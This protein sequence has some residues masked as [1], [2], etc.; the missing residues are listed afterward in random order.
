VHLATAA[1]FLAGTGTTHLGMPAR[2]AV[3]RRLARG[4]AP[5]VPQMLLTDVPMMA[6]EGFCAAVLLVMAAGSLP[7]MPWWALPAILCIAGAGLVG[8]RL[9]HERLPEQPLVAGLAILGAPGLRERLAGLTVTTVALTLARVGVVLA[10]CGLPSDPAH[11][12]LVYL[13]VSVLGLLPIG[14]ASNAA[15]TL[16]TAGAPSVGAGA[17]AGIALAAT[18]IAAAVVYA[19]IACAVAAT[20]PLAPARAREG[21]VREAAAAQR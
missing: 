18:S 15:A 13:A 6:L 14:A 20:R 1:G 8:I 9:V 12:V 16:A 17:A 5:R 19:A 21:R 4:S 2:L 3:L 7:A 11:V 10:A